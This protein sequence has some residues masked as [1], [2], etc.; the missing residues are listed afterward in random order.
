MKKRDRLQIIHDILSTIRDK[1]GKIRKTHILYKSNLSPQMLDDYLGEL[2]GKQL[3]EEVNS[4][5]LKTYKLTD[6]G[7]EFV[8]KYKMIAEFIESFGLS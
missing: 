1:D 2:L 3:V 6:K 8:A 7:F 5:G 4:K